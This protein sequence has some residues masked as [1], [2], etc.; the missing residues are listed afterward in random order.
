MFLMESLLHR[1]DTAGAEAELARLLGLHPKEQDALEEW[2]AEKRRSQVRW[3]QGSPG[4]V[5]CPRRIN[6]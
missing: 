3:S 1:N 4:A 5:S 2:Y 6:C